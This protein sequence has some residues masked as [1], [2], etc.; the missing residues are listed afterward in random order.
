MIILLRDQW[1]LMYNMKVEELYKWFQ[2]WTCKNMSP[3]FVCTDYSKQFQFE[4]I[5]RAYHF[6]KIKLEEKKKYIY[7]TLIEYCKEISDV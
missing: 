5:M 2:M 4:L 3:S 7:P 1:A 6:K